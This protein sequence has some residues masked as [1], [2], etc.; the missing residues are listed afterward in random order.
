MVINWA[1]AIVLFG[2]CLPGIFLAIPRLIKLLLARNSA[3]MQKR[4]SGYAMIQTVIMAGLMSFAGTVLSQKTGLTAPIFAALLQGKPVLSLLQSLLLPVFLTTIIGLGVFLF[5]YYG[6]MASIL[7]NH[8]LNALRKMRAAFRLDGCILYGGVVEE[9]I[10]RWGLMNVIAYFGL[11][12]VGKITPVIL[13]ISLLLSGLLLN[14]GHIPAYLAA[15]CAG[16]RRF[17]YMV[18]LLG[19][20]QAIAFG[21]LFIHYGLLAAILAH[22]LFHLGWYWYDKTE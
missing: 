1:L 13:V 17:I 10:A 21:W 8:S 14:L 2:L 4:I 7:D 11:L 18:L 16:S 12:L 6:I 20:W 22:N 3:E 5:L 19:L 9:V 15:G